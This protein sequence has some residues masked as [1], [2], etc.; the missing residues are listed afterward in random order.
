MCGRV[1]QGIGIR[2]GAAAAGMLGA[3]A[4][5]TPG[6]GGPSADPADP[7]AGDPVRRASFR[8]LAARDF[9]ATCPGLAGRPETARQRARLEELQQLAI[10]KGAG[11]AI[12]LG[13]N[14]WAAVARY[15]DREPCRPGEQAYG[16]ALA[17]FSA[18]LDEL[19]GRI[20]DYRP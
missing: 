7:A 9:L 12:G 19:A 10:R 18:T 1:T 2:A 6:C 4:L 13:A 20:A 8:S 11:Q 16:E 15:R 5:L 17:A 14:D 3:A